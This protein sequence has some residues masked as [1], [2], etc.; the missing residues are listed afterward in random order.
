S[1]R[2]RLVPAIAP[3]LF[4]VPAMRRFFFRTVSQINVNYRGSALSEGKA[5]D[6][7]AGDRLPWVRTNGSD[8]FATLTS[9]RWQVH[10]Y[11]RVP[12]GLEAA[13]S[14][15]G[16]ELCEFEWNDATSNAGLRESALYLIRPDGYVGLA[17]TS[18]D[19]ARFR[20]YLERVRS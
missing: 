11:G 4:R 15:L 12:T 18:I 13:C 8:N 17:D 1:V 9:L 16:I 14:E 6:V 2:T 3:V 7:V 5:G 10:V 19:V 20:S